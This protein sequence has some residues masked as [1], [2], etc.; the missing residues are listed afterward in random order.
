MERGLEP[1]LEESRSIDVGG[2]RRSMSGWQLSAT[3]PDWDRYR[4][5]QWGLM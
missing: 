3:G 2:R 4:K 5:Q 1:S